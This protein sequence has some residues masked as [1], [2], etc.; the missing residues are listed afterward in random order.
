MVDSIPEHGHRSY[1]LITNVVLSFCY[2]SSVIGELR[3]IGWPYVFLL[4]RDIQQLL[5]RRVTILTQLVP[6]Q[7]LPSKEGSLEPKDLQAHVDQTQF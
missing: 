4:S 7:L 1:A 2:R 5:K 3:R 6:C